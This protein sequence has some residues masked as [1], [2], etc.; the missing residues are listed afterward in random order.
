M[1]RNECDVIEL[2]ARINLRAFAHLFIVDHGSNDGTPAILE[3]LRLEGLPI[4]VLHEHGIQQTQAQTLTR[5]VRH[6]A[7]LGRYGYVVPLDADEFVQLP[8]GFEW[9]SLDETL[10]DAYYGQ[11]H[12]ATYVPMCGDFFG[13]RAPLH[14]HFR[15][16]AMALPEESK[17]VLPRAAALDCTLG[18][19]SHAAHT[20]S[21]H[22]PKVLPLSLCHAPVRSAGQL[23]RKA[24]IGTHVL[25]IKPDRLP[26]EGAHWD[27]LAAELRRRDY[28]CDD[29]FLKAMALRY[30]LPADAPLPRV[31]DEGDACAH[32]I[33]T[34]DD[35]IRHRDLAHIDV[36]AGLDG[37]LAKACAEINALSAIGNPAA[38]KRRWLRW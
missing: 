34:D 4:T 14:A 19:G 36:I 15:L 16:R 17:V 18:P 1:V 26:T 27:A 6:V 38:R 3:R 28:R 21:G 5:L 30:A 37:F 13:A 25:S 22:A 33:G 32:R 10:G 12:W 8:A 31:D 29:D 11:V 2:F 24:L 23:L 7:A 9:E 20:P 35:V